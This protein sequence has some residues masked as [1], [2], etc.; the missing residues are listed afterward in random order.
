M[1][2][3]NEI[4]LTLNEPETK[5]RDKIAKKLSTDSNR[6]WTKWYILYL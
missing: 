1:L 3:I 5:I 2:L 4:K 6:L